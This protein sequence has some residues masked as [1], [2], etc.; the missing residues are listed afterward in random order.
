MSKYVANAPLLAL[1]AAVTVRYSTS[2]GSICGGV[3]ND[4]DYIRL[5]KGIAL[6]SPLSLILGAFFLDGDG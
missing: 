6:G 2:S 5:L 3:Q 1:L 4:M